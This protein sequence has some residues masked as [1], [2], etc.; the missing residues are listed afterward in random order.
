M[1]RILI[2][3]LV[4]TFLAGCGSQDVHPLMTLNAPDQ[5]LRELALGNAE[6]AMAPFGS[7][8]RNADLKRQL[9]DYALLING[10]APDHCDCVRYERS[11][12][13]EERNYEE[14]TCFEITL[15]DGAVLYAI[16][17]HSE[18]SERIGLISFEL[19]TECPWE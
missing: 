7:D 16:C 3:I 15:E 13:I 17:R 9:E 6:G 11:G 10:R 14:T 8:V 19:Y 5:I 4:L 12:S 18:T 1:K 2:L